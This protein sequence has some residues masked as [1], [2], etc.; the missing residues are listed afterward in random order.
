MNFAENQGASLT[1]AAEMPD[2]RSPQVLPVDSSAAKLVVAHI[3]R[4]IVQ[5]KLSRGSRLRTERELCHELKLSRT[6]VRA[7]IQ[8]LVAKGVLVSRRGAAYIIPGH[9]TH[10]RARSAS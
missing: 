10:G 2:K 7:G 8:S 3:R 4:L 1:I 9:T 6:S 5:G